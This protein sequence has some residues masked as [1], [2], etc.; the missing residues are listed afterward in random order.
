[1]DTL[2]HDLGK[3]P[4]QL[5]LQNFIQPQAFP[6]RSALNWTYD[7]GNYEAALRLA[8][9]NVDYEGL[10][11]EQAEKRARGELM[12]IGIS[13]FTEIVGAGPGKHFD[14]AGIQM[15]NTSEIRVH[16]TAKILLRIC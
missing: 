16:P 8:M 14:I 2:A 4:A 3:E 10:R 5:R 7:S 12:G 15:F 9:K 13:S 1:M 11:R 6:Y